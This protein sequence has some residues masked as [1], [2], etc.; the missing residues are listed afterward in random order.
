MLNEIIEMADGHI[1]GVTVDDEAFP[2]SPD[3]D[4]YYSYLSA[5]VYWD[6]GEFFT[7]AEDYKIDM[8]KVI[9]E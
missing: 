9:R 1:M 4:M 7:L 8:D 2:F 6:Y 3:A 5:A